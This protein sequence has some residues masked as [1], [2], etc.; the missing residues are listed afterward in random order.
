MPHTYNESIRRSGGSS[1]GGSS[2]ES[3]VTEGEEGG[4]DGLSD[5]ATAVSAP[6]GGRREGLQLPRGLP[7]LTHQ[8]AE[9]HENISI[10]FSDVVGFT[11][12]AQKVH[13]QLVMTMLNDMY[14]RFDDLCLASGNAI[15]KVET[16]GD[17]LM[18]A[19]GLMHPDPDH[20]AT[21]VRF[22]LA[23]RKAAAKVM[24]PTTGQPVQIRI[25]V[26]SGRAMSGIVGKL[27]RRFCLFGDTV[28]TASRMES[29]GL[30]GSVHISQHTYSLIAHLPAFQFSCRGSMEIKGKG[31]MTTW[32]VEPKGS[33]GSAKLRSLPTTPLP[34]PPRQGPPILSPSTDGQLAGIEFGDGVDEEGVLGAPAPCS[35]PAA[36][37]L[38]PCPSAGHSYKCMDSGDYAPPGAEAV[39]RH[40]LLSAAACSLST[41]PQSAA[42]RPSHLQPLNNQRLR[43]SL[44]AAE[45]VPAS[46]SS[47]SPP[48]IDSYL[49]QAQEHQ[50]AWEQYQQR[51]PLGQQ[52]VLPPAPSLPL[53]VRPA[54]LCT[55]TS[56]AVQLA[57]ML[58]MPVFS[59]SLGRGTMP[60][61]ITHS[62]SS[63]LTHSLSFGRRQHLSN[64]RGVAG[65]ETGA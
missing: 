54:G 25:G 46:V 50:Q 5:L 36:P 39:T 56:P 21:A 60:L 49:Q 8:L 23:M 14:T 30:A 10:I 9:W 18:A 57:P 28:N 37:S 43:R 6:G 24:L 26:H 52:Q 35:T 53:V 1:E 11:D 58:P 16:I 38:S 22:A 3:K 34:A 64:E 4:D 44:G 12:M 42:L 20:A 33:R 7:S 41:R 31:Q 13:P 40:A 32:W 63:N 59:N 19:A 47:G 2:E 62:S 17:S 27:R 51:Q 55:N 29:S 48:D 65:E 61:R 45:I 15:Y